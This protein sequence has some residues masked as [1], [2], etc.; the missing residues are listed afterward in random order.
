M[1]QNVQND[2]LE[3]QV[4]NPAPSDVPRHALR[5]HENEY[6]DGGREK[7]DDALYH[8]TDRAPSNE[9]K[10]AHKDAQKERVR[11]GK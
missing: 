7:H 8:K 10:V 5:P 1:E 6:G 3:P 11:K 9:L 4:H 2:K